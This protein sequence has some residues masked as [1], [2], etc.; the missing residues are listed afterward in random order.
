MGVISEKIEN[1]NDKTKDLVEMYGHMVLSFRKC[2]ALKEAGKPFKDE[3]NRLHRL[4]N[5]VDPMWSALTNTEQM[6]A[7]KAL[8][9]NGYMSEEVANVLTMFGGRIDNSAPPEPCYRIP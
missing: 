8:T 5:K 7:V 6:I 2:Q 9:K 4:E 1:M 3:E